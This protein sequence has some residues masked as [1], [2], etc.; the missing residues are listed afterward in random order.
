MCEGRMKINVDTGKLNLPGPSSGG[1]VTSPCVPENERTH[2]INCLLELGLS[3]AEIDH[4]LASI[5]DA[6]TVNKLVD[7]WPNQ[8]DD[9]K[10]LK[11][12]A[13][14]A[15]GLAMVLAGLSP[16]ARAELSHVS[17]FDLRDVNAAKNLIPTLNTLAGGLRHRVSQ[18][19]KQS[20]AK[21]KT[22]LVRLVY[23]LQ[24]ARLGAPVWW[25]ESPFY[26]ACQQVFVLAG[27]ATFNAKGAKPYSP[28]R[29]IKALAT[30][31][32]KTGG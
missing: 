26:I 11:A 20:R 9:N 4:L 16:K 31:I 23:G 7:T 21:P 17:H 10:A 22:N 8:G 25:P 27:Q 28:D 24:S 6:H 2:A 3:Q 18:L 5:P 12:A 32:E 30:W 13:D 14:L 1:F 29:A 19:P 15:Q